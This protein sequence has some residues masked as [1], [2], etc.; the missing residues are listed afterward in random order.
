MPTEQSLMDERMLVEL[1][2]EMRPLIET[3]RQELSSL[4]SA[5][6]QETVERFFSIAPV[7]AC[8]RLANAW[9]LAVTMGHDMHAFRERFDMEEQFL[10][11]LVTS[12][13]TDALSEHQGILCNLREVARLIDESEFDPASE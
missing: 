6:G 9:A 1:E 4:M 3:I 13:Y 8:M 10:I 12:I 7:E 2:T 11:E 5:S